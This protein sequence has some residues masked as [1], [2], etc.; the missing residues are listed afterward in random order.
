MVRLIKS[1]DQGAFVKLYQQYHGALYSFLL[2][3]LKSPDQVKD[4]VQD[5]FVKVWERRASLNEDLSVKS[6]IFT[7]GK[8]LMLNVLKR[9]SN[10]MLLSREIY[11]YTQHTNNFTEESM[12]NADYERIAQNAIRQL[13]P[14]RKAI[15]KMCRHEGKSYEEVANELQVTKSTIN[16]Q[17]VK[18]M[19][20]IKAY[21][22]IY[23]D[24]TLAIAV[25]F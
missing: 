21:L 2:K 11:F 16:G 6:Y 3:F 12:L 25:F 5:T 8:N 24:I 7:I 17:M 14:Q 10:E 18:A 20:S 1:G 23:A 22:L 9:A 13:P 4:I 19:K 15:F